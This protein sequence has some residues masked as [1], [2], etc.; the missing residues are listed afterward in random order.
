MKNKIKEITYEFGIISIIAQ[1]KGGLLIKYRKLAKQAAMY[2]SELRNKD[3]KWYQIYPK[4]YLHSYGY[5][6]F[7]DNQFINA[8]EEEMENTFK[9]LVKKQKL[10]I[11]NDTNML[12]YQKYKGN[13]LYEVSCFDKA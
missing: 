3:I 6:S 10:G 2:L 1:G 7:Y 4:I 11:L 8:T 5:L 12:F 9:D 13:K